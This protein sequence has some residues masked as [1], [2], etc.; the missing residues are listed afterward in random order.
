[1]L[2]SL[3]TC[4]REVTLQASGQLILAGATCLLQEVVSD[5][6]WA[7]CLGLCQEVRKLV[8]CIASYVLCF[9]YRQI[10]GAKTEGRKGDLAFVL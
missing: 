5:C 7:I 2:P 1:M 6:S 8:I 9:F 10:L 3:I 4:V